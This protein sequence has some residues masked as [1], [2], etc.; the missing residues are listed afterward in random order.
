MEYANLLASASK[1]ASGVYRQMKEKKYPHYRKLTGK[2]MKL[3][4]AGLTEPDVISKMAP[5]KK[6]R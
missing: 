5:R 6:I 2:A 4:K 1:I 3:L